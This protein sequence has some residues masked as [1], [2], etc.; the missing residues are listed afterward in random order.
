M[1]NTVLKKSV[2]EFLFKHNM[3]VKNIDIEKYVM[4]FLD[5]MQKGLVNEPSSLKMFPTFIKFERKVLINKPVIVLDAGGTNFRKAVVHF[6]SDF[7][8]VIN[9]YNQYKM[10]GLNY[11]VSKNEFFNYIASFIKDILN[12]SD[13]IAFIFSYPSEIFPN[14]DGRLVRWCKEIKAKE[15]EGELIGE[16]LKSAIKEFG[17]N[18]EKKIVILNDTV[19]TLLSGV[20]AFQ[21][22]EFDSYIGFVLGTGMNSCYI[23]QNRN[24]RKDSVMTLNPDDYQIVNIEAGNFAKGPR[25]DVD[26]EFDSKTLDPGMYTFEKMMSGAYLG[27]LVIETVKA[28]LKEELFTTDFL[29]KAGISNLDTQYISDFFRY[30]PSKENSLLEAMKFINEDEIIKFYYLLDGLVEKAAIL[31]SI[32]LSSAIKKSEKGANPCRPVC[33]IA[34]GS[35]FYNLKNFSFRVEYYMNKILGDQN[36]YEIKKVDDATIVGATVAGLCN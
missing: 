34:E 7:M 10:P 16:N 17:I 21:N 13:S 5:E 28:A 2:D 15:V 20:S 23:E 33:I 35:S 1:N 9:N 36:Y 19:A 22:R 29:A 18:E 14:K 24:I 26:Y 12:E 32:V 8:P 25:G 11:E 4:Y 30:P 27:G 6:N 3:H 31:S